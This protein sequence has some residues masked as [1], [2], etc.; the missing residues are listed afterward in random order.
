MRIPRLKLSIAVALAV[1]GVGA[2]VAVAAPVRSAGTS[3]IT[4]ALNKTSKVTSGHLA[5]ALT[6]SGGGISSSSAV[7]VT[8][9]G[10]FD[11]KHQTSTFT[12]NLG[13]LAGLLGGA[14]GGAAIPGKLQV[15]AL[16]NALYVHLPSVATQIK[17]GA[18]WVKFD[19]SGI[20]ASVTQGVKPSDLSK[21]NPQKVLAQLTSSVS[22]HKLGTATVRGASTT[23]YRVSV[24]TAKVV[25]ILPKSQQ[26]AELKAL[27]SMHLKTLPLD[28]YVDHSGYVRRVGVSLSNLKVQ[29]GSAAVAIKLQVDLYDFGTHVTVS[30][31]PASKTADGNKLLQQLIPSGTGG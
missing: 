16:K 1:V 31:P 19:A 5:F 22:V 2:A 29:T 30:A 4:Q 17:K 13:A 28:V 8:G 25:G 11:T 3:P 18:E 6:L 9:T 14:S 21:I 20:P 10:G 12:L 15:V 23:H 7:A 27:K 26:A 24:N